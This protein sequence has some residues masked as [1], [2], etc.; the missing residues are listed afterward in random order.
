MAIIEAPTLL[1]ASVTKK[2]GVVDAAPRVASSP[3]KFTIVEV[4]CERPG[5]SRNQG[6][7]IC[8][9]HFREK[10]RQSRQRNARDVLNCGEKDRPFGRRRWRGSAASAAQRSGLLIRRGLLGHQGPSKGQGPDPWKD[11]HTR[12]TVDF[13]NLHHRHTTIQG[14]VIVSGSFPQASFL[15]RCS[16]WDKPERWLTAGPR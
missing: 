9:T 13:C 2:G 15:L 6:E 11:P 4:I 5:Q 14:F 3:R 8:R 12:S 10:K 1:P 7:P 16:S